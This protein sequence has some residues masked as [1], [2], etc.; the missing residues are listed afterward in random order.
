VILTAKAVECVASLFRA[1]RAAESESGFGKFQKLPRTFQISEYFRTFQ[2][3]STLQSASALDG[4][5]DPVVE[6]KG[7]V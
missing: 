6:H 4:Y 7:N 2:K 1:G 5:E 3:V